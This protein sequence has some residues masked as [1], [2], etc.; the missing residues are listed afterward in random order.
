M[1]FAY[2]F[3]QFFGTD[4]ILGVHP[5]HVPF[6]KRGFGFEPF[7]PEDAHPGVR[8]H[9][10]VPII[11]TP[12]QVIA[13][14]PVPRGLAYLLE[15]PVARDE[16]DRCCDLTTPAVRASEIGQFLATRPGTAPSSLAV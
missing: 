8:H 14:P 7:G 10:V 2:Y 9:P 4:V 12:E 15:R 3:Q 13:H 1:R 6:W 11:F 5:H 16:Y